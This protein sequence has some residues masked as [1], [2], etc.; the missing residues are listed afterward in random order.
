M[1][2]FTISENRSHSM[3]HIKNKPEEGSYNTLII[4]L[5]ESIWEVVP[6]DEIHP[7]LSL[8]LSIIGNLPPNNKPP[9][10]TMLRRI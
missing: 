4:V 2:P 6:W 8:Y 9:A 7:L 3:R 10:Q 1:T 5:R